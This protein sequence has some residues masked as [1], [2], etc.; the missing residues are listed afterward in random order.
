MPDRSTGTVTYLSRA[1]HFANYDAAT[2]APSE[3]MYVMNDETREKI[4]EK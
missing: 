4:M 3:D 1:N 2:A